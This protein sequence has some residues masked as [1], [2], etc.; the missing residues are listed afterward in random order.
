M[1]TERM[2][3]RDATL[4]SL[5]R[6]L[7]QA[8]G[9]DG[10]AALLA[11]EAGI[12][13]STAIRAFCA[14]VA[15]RARVV[16]GG[17]DALATPRALAPLRDMAEAL[18]SEFR[19]VLDASPAR[20]AVFEATLRALKATTRPTVMILEDLHWA[21]EA[22]LDLLRFLGRRIRGTRVLAVVTYRDDE[23]GPR[24]PLR[25]VLGDLASAGG[26]HRLTLAPLSEG[27]VTELARGT[28]VDAAALWHA[29]G[30]N[31]FF[32]TEV[33]AAGI[34]GVPVTVGDAVAARTA[35]LPEGA[36]WALETAAV[37]GGEVD[38]AMLVELG[39]EPA[40]LDACVAGGLLVERG[41]GL[42]FRHQLGEDAVREALAPVRRRA[43]HGEVLRALERS[44]TDGRDLARLV[45]HAD[46]SG[47][48]AAVL[49]WAPHAAREAA[50]LGAHREAY[51]HLARAVHHRSVLPPAERAELLGA[52]AIAAYRMEEL[53]AAETAWR[54]EATLWQELDQ[55]RLCGRAHAYLASAVTAQGRNA[56]GDATILRALEILEP[57]GVVP[58]LA[59]AVGVHANLRMLDRDHDA[60]VSAGRRAV[61]LAQRT[62]SAE[63]EIHAL[64]DL[65]A[66]LL[67]SGA[68]VEAR[69]H[70]A[71]SVE[72][73]ERAGGSDA[74]ARAHLI[75]GS[76]SGE[77]HDFAEAERHLREAVRLFEAAELEGFHRYAIAW[78]GLVRA[79]L[80]DWREAT[81]LALHVV[82][83]VP[84]SP[85]S[86][87]MALVGLG[88]VRV[89][90]GDP[91]AGAALD[92]ALA[93]ADRTGTLQRVAPVRAA[94]AEAAALAGRP[95]AVRSEARAAYELALARRH[96][97]F[98]GEL[99]YWR[100]TVGDLDAL[101]GFA[102]EPYALQVAGRAVDAAAAWE[103]LGCPYE[104]ARALAASTRLEDL[105]EAHAVFGELGARP[106][107]AAVARRLRDLGLRGVAR[108]PRAATTAHPAGLTPREAEVLALLVGGRRNAEIAELLGVSP[109][110]VGHQVSALLAKLGVRTR[111]EAVTEAHRRGLVPAP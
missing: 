54:E 60:A 90:R 18:G 100:W 79:H 95:E 15:D 32:V 86:E 87:I 68:S 70:L 23:V 85:M 37:V 5:E 76:G 44:D 93:L 99:G 61:D 25:T 8:A 94:R 92:E 111:T 28:G 72:L 4:A 34:V 75:L 57:E 62:G 14:A 83:R 103:A 98:V 27:A 77:L 6:L 105:R 109:R 84:P 49:R 69:T 80:G 88:R 33:L 53:E 11:G 17:C 9:G 43:L 56:E 26:V 7:R 52:F 42:A 63:R 13:K 104:R 66:A 19:A 10:C 3:E 71:R 110:T 106:A 41:R 107:A 89:R 108:G 22:T 31:P 46:A 29:T 48:G 38:P 20:E 21:D 67:M 47:D 82:G 39:A 51:A 74:V 78:L 36:R 55:A 2:L 64:A 40:D 1:R 97:W 65:G 101:P 91:D 73:A 96:P 24:H 35:R 58:E 45:H 16:V 50:R 59:F 102:A 12:G 81:E 30:G